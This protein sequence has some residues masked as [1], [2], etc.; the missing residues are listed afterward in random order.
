MTDPITVTTPAEWNAWL[1]AHPAEREVWVLFH[2]K[3]TGIASLTWEQAVIEALAHG[4]IDG[5]KKSISDTQ[6]IQRFTPRRPGSAWSQ[7]NVAHVEKLIAEGRMTPSGLAHVTLAKDN[8]RWEAAYAGGRAGEMPP[9][10]LA[11]LAD[12]PAASA[13]YETLDAKNRFAIYYRLTSVKRAET[14]TRKIAEFV[15]LLARGERLV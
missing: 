10:F 9:E 15:A 7:K 13:T 6:W 2:K 12:N 14:R 11:A 3:A 5:I 4:W 8:G 1:A